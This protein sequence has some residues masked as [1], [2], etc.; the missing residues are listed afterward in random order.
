M[1]NQLPCNGFLRSFRQRLNVYARQ[2]AADTRGSVTVEFII[3]MPIIFYAFMGIYV[4]FEGY[5]QSTINLKAAYTISDLISRETEIISDEYIDSM[6]AMMQILTRSNSTIALRMSVFRWSDDDNR[7]FVEWSQNRGY[8]P[9]YT[10]ASISAIEDKLPLLPNNEIVILVETD[11]T[12]TP[13]FKVGM[14]DKQL[15]NF[16]FTKPR[17]VDQLCYL[18]DGGN[19][20]P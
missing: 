4:Y 2:F 3:M 20:C 6:Q 12:Y 13:L 15:K 18:P 19:Q 5:R 10:N 9:N 1:Q 16:V 17:W 14:D 11:N 7:F 8:E